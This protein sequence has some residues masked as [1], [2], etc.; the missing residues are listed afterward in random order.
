MDLFDWATVE[1]V[2]SEAVQRAG[3]H[4]DPRWMQSA[5][6]AVTESAADGTF[7]TDDVWSVLERWNV[8]APHE[9]RAMGAVMRSMAKKGFIQATGTYAKSK[10]LECHGRPVMVWTQA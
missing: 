4:A 5:E 6:R 8:P 3:D 10:R 1:K 7:T 9:P 2:T